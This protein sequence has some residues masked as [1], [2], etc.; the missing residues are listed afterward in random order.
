MK[1]CQFLN[2][3]SMNASNYVVGLWLILAVFMSG[4]SAARGLSKEE[5]IAEE[6]AL[7]EA[8]ENR[9]YVIEVDRAIPM[10][11]SSRMLTSPYSLTINGDE[12]K[13]HLP[14]FGRAYT[15]PYGGGEGLIFETTSINYQLT[16]EKRGK[17][18]IEF[19]ANTQEDRHI[20]RI[21]IFANGSS[22]ISVTPTNRQ[23][24]SFSGRAYPKRPTDN[25]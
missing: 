8:I 11:G 18:V 7:R 14:F 9:M 17:A 13:S 23:S 12:V 3:E 19:N 22:S 21:Q 15:I 10:S 20:F 25:Q 16:W 4:C 2:C 5:R 1:Y 6:A 24:I